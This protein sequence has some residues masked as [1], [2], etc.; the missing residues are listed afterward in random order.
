MS[1]YFLDYVS[2]EK[3]SSDSWLVSQRLGRLVIHEI[4]LV[5]SKK[6]AD[7]P[8]SDD[9]QEQATQLQKCR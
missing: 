9:E 1:D 2:C 8:T 5:E 7:E 4:D 3:Y 6:S